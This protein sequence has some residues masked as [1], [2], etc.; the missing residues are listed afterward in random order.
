MIHEPPG[1]SPASRFPALMQ[2]YTRTLIETA[3]R[4]LDGAA[5]ARYTEAAKEL[6]EWASRC[7]SKVLLLEE[8]FKAV[9]GFPA[10]VDDILDG[11]SGD[12][13]VVLNVH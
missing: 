11:K 4:P 5:K 2:A 6:L 10:N 12:A 8:L 1:Y 13:T 9:T 7:E 3:S